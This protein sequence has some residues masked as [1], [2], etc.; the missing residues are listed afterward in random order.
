MQNTILLQQ[1]IHQLCTENQRRKRKREAPRY[2]I[3]AGGSL[4]GAEGQQKA[5]ELEQLQ[6]SSQQPWRP[7]RCIKY[8]EFCYAKKL[9][10]QALLGT[11]SRGW[12]GSSVSDYVKFSL[13]VNKFRIGLYYIVYNL[14]NL[15]ISSLRKSYI[16]IL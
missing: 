16:K 7:P 9:Y 8:I 15:R 6:E 10:L 13:L 4:T 1:E 14:K 2:F 3:Q 12:G 11:F 5:R